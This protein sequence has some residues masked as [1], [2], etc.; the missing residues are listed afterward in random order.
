MVFCSVKRKRIFFLALFLL[1][2]LLVFFPH[3]SF[4][5]TLGET[6]VKF[7]NKFLGGILHG[8]ELLVGLFQFLFLEVIKLTILDFSGEWKDGALY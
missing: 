3:I 2:L 1:L 7:F 8:M 4:A 6:L 5:E